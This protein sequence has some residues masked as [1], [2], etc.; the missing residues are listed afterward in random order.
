M[1]LLTVGAA[2]AEVG[3]NVAPAAVGCSVVGEAEGASV[4]F[5]VGL[6]VGLEVGDPV[7]SWSGF[8]IQMALLSYPQ[9]LRPRHCNVRTSIMEQSFINKTHITL[10]YGSSCANNGKGALNTPDNIKPY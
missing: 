6:E 2:E 8:A 5:F 9:P 1:L 10:C 4:G 7:N 3:A